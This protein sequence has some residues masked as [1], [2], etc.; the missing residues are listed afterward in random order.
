[1]SS[2][3]QNYDIGIIISI[4]YLRRKPETKRE[5]EAKRTKNHCESAMYKTPCS[6]FYVFHFVQTSS[7]HDEIGN[8]IIIL[9]MRK[10]EA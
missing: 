1:M 6:A 2:W 3:F 9:H 7:Y 5:R 10:I 8:I 4:F